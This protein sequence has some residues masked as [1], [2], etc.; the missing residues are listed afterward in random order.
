[1]LEQEPGFQVT[2]PLLQLAAIDPV[3][4]ALMFQKLTVSPCEMPIEANALQAPKRRVSPTVQ[5]A[6]GVDVVSNVAMALARGSSAAAATV[7]VLAAAVLPAPLDWVPEP[8]D[9]TTTPRLAVSLLLA[10]AVVWLSDFAVA[11]AVAGLLKVE[12]DCVR[13]PSDAMAAAVAVGVEAAAVSAATG[14]E[15]AKATAEADDSALDAAA[16]C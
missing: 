14:A 4:P 2:T 1:M 8:E 3:T 7:S 5:R 6:P 13:G 16:A 11:V 15:A 9:A 10:F 12:A